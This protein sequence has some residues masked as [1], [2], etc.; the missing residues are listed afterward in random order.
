[1]TFNL[2]IKDAYGM[3]QPTFEYTPTALY[4]EETQKMMNDMTDVANKF[5]AYLPSCNPGILYFLSKITLKLLQS[6]FLGL[7]RFAPSELWGTIFRYALPDPMVASEI[8]AEAR[9]NLYSICR[10]S[11]TL[12]R[13]DSYFWS[14][15]NI[16]SR[17]SILAL[18]S[19]VGRIS[20]TGGLHIR[21]SL[22]SIGEYYLSAP[23]SHLYAHLSSLLD[24][25]TPLS[26][27]WMSFSLSTGYP[28]LFHYINSVCADLAAPALRELSIDSPV[29]PYDDALDVFATVSASDHPLDDHPPVWFSNSISTLT[30]VRSDSC[31][32][33]LLEL[34]AH[35]NLVSVDLSDIVQHLDWTVL[36]TLFDVSHCLSRF[37]VRNIPRFPLPPSGLLTSSSVTTVVLDFGDTPSRHMR[38]F[39]Q[40]LSF[41]GLVE[42]TLG[43]DLWVNIGFLGGCSFLSSAQRLT[44]RGAWADQDLLVTLFPLLLMVTSL[45]LSD[46]TGAFSTLRN[47]TLMRSMSS[48]C[49]PILPLTSLTLGWTDLYLLLSFLSLYPSPSLPGF[50]SITY[51]CFA[52]PTYLTE[53]VLDVIRSAVKECVLTPNYVSSYYT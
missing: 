46:S 4:A 15:L 41:P 13:A 36:A 11:R 31:S 39:V 5:G 27:R 14:R 12:L 34:A 16:D 23:S 1:M 35:G 38:E 25:V 6:E 10:G 29:P 47:W 49:L 28:A 3:P 17:T 33:S 30:R 37:R 48:P 9:A 8:H 44:A 2:D 45:D 21:F 18:R 51:V 19:V 26:A 52:R 32:I 53:S 7:T 42:L 50:S 22:D 40:R 24:V 43:C 20:P